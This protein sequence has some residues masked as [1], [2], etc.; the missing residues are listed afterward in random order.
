MR[1][2]ILCLTLLLPGFAQAQEGG[3]LADIRQDLSELFS[4]VQSLRDEL[5]GTG[6]SQMNLAGTSA[7]GRIDA[8]EAEL[9]RLTGETEELEFR[10]NRVV[11]DGTNRVGDLEFRICELEP[12]CDIGGLGETPTL[13]GESGSTPVA[14]PSPPPN[15]GGGAQLAVGEQQDFD[16]AKEA[17][18]SGSFRSAADLFETFAETYTSGP[19]TTEAHYLRAEAL[20]QLGDNAESAR[21]YLEAFSGAP[22]GPL[23]PQALLNL[24]LKLDV[25]DQRADSCATLGEVTTRYPQSDASVEAQAAWAGLGCS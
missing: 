15:Q 8:M 13:G 9:R 3:T 11:T 4:Q 12:N 2:A 18:D 25:L 22:Q 16:R 21:A 5:D 7:L 10:I 14:R 24:G 1:R 19:L 6:S 23:A 20:S 17:L